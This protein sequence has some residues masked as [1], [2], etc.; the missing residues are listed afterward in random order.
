FV[1]IEFESPDE[2]E[3]FLKLYK[4]LK[5]LLRDGDGIVVML[6]NFTPR[7]IRKVIQPLTQAGIFVELSGGINERN[8][9]KYNIAGVSAISS[10]SITSRADNL[11]FS[12]Q[13]TKK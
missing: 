8:V 4:K 2:V 12:L 11:D 1:E 6:D 9:T 7:D 3:K 5:K 13:V 10:G